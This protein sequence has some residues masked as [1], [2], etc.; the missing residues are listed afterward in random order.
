MFILSIGVFL[1][2]IIELAHSNY[3]K[4]RNE[5]CLNKKQFVKKNFVNFLLKIELQKFQKC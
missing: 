1:R 4:Y 5:N 2:D 3:Q